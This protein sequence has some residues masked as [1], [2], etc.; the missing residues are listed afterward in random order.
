MAPLIDIDRLTALVHETGVEYIT[1][2]KIV[3][4][5]WQEIAERYCREKGVDLLPYK[6]F[7]SRWKNAKFQAKKKAERPRKY[8]KQDETSDV[9]E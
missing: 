4:N 2:S 5:T 7:S 8:L 6:S 9:S 1:N 3:K